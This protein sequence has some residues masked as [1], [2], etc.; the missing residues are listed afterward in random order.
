MRVL[1]LTL[2]LSPA[3]AFPTHRYKVPNGYRVPCP[4]DGEGCLVDG[5]VG[6]A[7]WTTARKA[8]P[9]RR[10][11]AAAVAPTPRGWGVAGARGGARRATRRP[12]ARGTRT[13]SGSAR[14]RA[15]GR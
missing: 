13:R 5:N 15:G 1:I 8:A 6:D 10:P 9:G 3:A 2:A 12:A 7:P 11:H 14:P 4:A